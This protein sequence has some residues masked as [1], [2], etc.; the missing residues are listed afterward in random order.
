MRLAYEDYMT[1]DVYAEVNPAFGTYVL[2]AF[3][4]TYAQVVPEGPE[5]PT[6]YL[7][8]PIAMS[9]DLKD[10]FGGTNKNTGLLEWLDRNPK[11]HVGLSDRVNASMNIVTETLSF[12]CFSGAIHIA[13][14]RLS[15]DQKRLKKGAV[16]SLRNDSKQVIK[17][18]ER[19]GHW[20]STAGSTQT[21][22]DMMRL[23]A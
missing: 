7:T 3:V 9:G 17:R 10:T 20:F 22:F 18:A 11:I 15:H 2:S 8:L 19:L 21:I 6:I 13:E 16:N 1:H 14:N 12:A 23:S 4:A 5:I